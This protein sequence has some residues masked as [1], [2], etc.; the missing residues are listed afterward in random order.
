[1]AKKTEGNK[2]AR[3]K[4]ETAK[5]DPFISGRLTEI[6]KAHTSEI[7][8]VCERHPGIEEFTSDEWKQLDFVVLE[9]LK[10]MADVRFNS[11]FMR[12]TPLKHITPYSLSC[13]VREE[14]SKKFI[15]GWIDRIGETQELIDAVEWDAHCCWEIFCHLAIMI[16]E[17]SKQ[18]EDK[19]KED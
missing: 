12:M 11:H 9:V 19:K 10:A 3:K 17:N 2:S 8:E 1:M 6:I 5:Y 16:A 4:K 7:R 15:I 18:P 13:K 14:Q